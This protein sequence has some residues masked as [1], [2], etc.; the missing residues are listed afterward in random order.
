MIDDHSTT[1]DTPS[2]LYTYLCCLTT[3][4]HYCD[5]LSFVIL[6]K[7]RRQEGLGRVF[8]F[9]IG[10]L[11]SHLSCWIPSRNIGGFPIWLALAPDIPWAVNLS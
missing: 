9:A 7:A 4:L 8:L 10:Y 11:R 6:S 1:H 5:K 3:A 2:T